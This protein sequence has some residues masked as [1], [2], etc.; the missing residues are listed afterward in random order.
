[1]TDTAIYSDSAERA[2]LAV[3]MMDGNLI[4]TID[5]TPQEFFIRRYG[6]VYNS[7]QALVKKNKP[8][9]ILTVSELLRARG[10]LDE[11][12][13]FTALSELMLDNVTYTALPEYVSII[14]DKANRR[15]AISLCGEIAKAAADES[16]AYNAGEFANRILQTQA[17]AT[18]TMHISQALSSF[19]DWQTSRVE[20]REKGEL[21]MLATTHIPELDN[22]LVYLEEGQETIVA[23][24]P[25]VGKTMLVQQIVESNAN[26]KS[27]IFSMEMKATRLTA[28]LVSS[29][30]GVPV[31]QM[32]MGL[33]YNTEKM[34][35][36]IYDAVAELEIAGIY[37][38]DRPGIT[39][40]GMYSET[41]RLKASG[42]E[43]G[44]CAIDYFDLIN[45]GGGAENKNEREG[46]VSSKL[47][48]MFRE[49]A[50]HGLV[51][52]TYKTEGFVAC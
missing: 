2:V 23:G 21:G 5:L 36:L 22:L 33:P 52:D 19:L 11:I 47:Q 1:M 35:Q 12:G 49:L 34:Q 3:L 41:A 31:T 15:A 32:R 29:R 37:I 26:M 50:V 43:I 8:V 39:V 28:R 46:L 18:D 7:I 51:I 48:R 9:D 6:V 25:G 27:I 16:I 10:R 13:G 42:I 24:E 38:N 14:R 4:K 30:C 17:Q 20:M 40:E 45:D 44:L